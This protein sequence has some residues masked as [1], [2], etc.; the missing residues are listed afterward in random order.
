MFDSG[1]LLRVLSENEKS[2]SVSTE[3]IA[4][5]VTVTMARD[6]PVPAGIAW[7]S[8][9][10]S[11]S[12]TTPNVNPPERISGTISSALALSV[13]VPAVDRSVTAAIE[14]SYATAMTKPS[15]GSVESSDIDRV[16]G[17]RPCVLELLMLS[18]CPP[19]ANTEFE[20]TRATMIHVNART[21]KTAFVRYMISSLGHNVRATKYKHFE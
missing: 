21:L 9:G 3:T 8:N 19:P 16:A 5:G 14:S 6:W 7:P 4:I 12:T 2:M 10:G 17:A 20:S 11:E 15:V 13:A 18:D 1:G